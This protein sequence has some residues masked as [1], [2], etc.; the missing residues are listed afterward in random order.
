M[1][2]VFLHMGVNREI[3]HTLL[4][5]AYKVLDELRTKGISRARHAVVPL[6]SPFEVSYIILDVEQETTDQQ[7]Q[8]L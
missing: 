7:A 5:S 3:D 2:N 4:M 6:Y 1:E 8:V